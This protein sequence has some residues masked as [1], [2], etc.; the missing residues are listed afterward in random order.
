[1]ATRDKHL[2]LTGASGLLGRAIYKK[3]ITEGW[4]IYGTA[5]TRVAEGLHKLDLTD[6]NE[7]KKAVIQFKP[8]FLIHCAAQRFPEKVDLDPEGAENINI[9]ASRYLAQ[10]VDCIQVPM[11]Y[12]STDYVFDGKSPPYAVDAVPNPLNLYGKTKLN[13]EEVTLAFGKG[14]IVL[15]VPVLYG[16]V[17]YVA[18]SAVTVLLNSL[19]Q[20]DKPCKISNYELR[21]PS[22]VD[23]IAD[24]CLQMAMKRLEVFFLD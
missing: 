1:M 24:I 14:N 19:L 21:R 9:N 23:D 20:T 13:G 22:H 16:P 3:F 11:L 7:V 18:E 17:E 6:E 12:I 10:V 8:S 15:R 4:V 2:F 5:Y